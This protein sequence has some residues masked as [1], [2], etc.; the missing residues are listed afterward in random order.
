MTEAVILADDLNVIMCGKLDIKDILLFLKTAY[1]EFN[2][3]V[4]GPPYYEHAE[5]GGVNSL[6]DNF[7]RLKG[8]ITESSYEFQLHS[9]FPGY[10][11]ISKAKGLFNISINCDVWFFYYGSLLF[12]K[13]YEKEGGFSERQIARG[14]ENLK[15]LIELC[16]LLLKH[17]NASYFYGGVDAFEDTESACDIQFLFCKE[18]DYLELLQ[19]YVKGYF[20]V[21]LSNSEIKRIVERTAEITKDGDCVFLNFMYIR[22]DALFPQDIFNDA[23]KKYLE[24]KK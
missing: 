22:K 10:L 23:V 11:K 21:Q 13:D 12:Y 17:S 19:R 18:S 5:S 8:V 9:S 4:F 2:G 7:N 6:V 1:G 24:G 20:K 15:E 3:K 14:K 16:K